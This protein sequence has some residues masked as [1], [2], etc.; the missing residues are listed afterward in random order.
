MNGFRGWGIP[1][2]VVRIRALV[3]KETLQ[4]IRDPSSLAIAFLLPF[5]LLLIFGY[6]VSLGLVKVGRADEQ[7]ASGL[8]DQ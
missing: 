6:G 3:R 5:V 7:C 8:P 1:P 2:S 4:I